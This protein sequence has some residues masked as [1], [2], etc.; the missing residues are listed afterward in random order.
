MHVTLERRGVVP[1]SK[2]IEF[3]QRAEQDGFDAIGGRAI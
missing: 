1:R 2:A 3:A